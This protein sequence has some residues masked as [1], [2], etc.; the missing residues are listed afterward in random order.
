M[1]RAGGN[2]MHIVQYLYYSRR[3]PPFFCGQS[4]LFQKSD[5]ER[6]T[7]SSVQNHPLEYY[8]HV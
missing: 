2:H 4:A 1:V 3:R 8:L 6:A 5:S 7:Q